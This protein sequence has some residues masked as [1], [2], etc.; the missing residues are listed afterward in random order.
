MAPII[1]PSDAPKRRWQFSL[2]ALFIVITAAAVLAAI[3]WN[4]VRFLAIPLLFYAVVVGI[5]LLI[6]RAIE[7]S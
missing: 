4:N 6:R 3:P 1:M 2:R 5:P 7:R